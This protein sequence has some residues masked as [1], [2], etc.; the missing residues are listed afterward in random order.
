MTFSNVFPQFLRA[1][2]FALIGELGITHVHSMP[3]KSTLRLEA[4]GAYVSG[5]PVH[6]A[7][8]VQ[9]ATEPD[10]SF[11][12]ATSWGY[13]IRGRF[14]YNNAIGP[15]ALIPSFAW[16]HDVS[17]TTPGPGGNFLDGR[18][19][20]SLGLGTNL[21]NV[22]TADLR[23]TSFFGAGRQNLINDRD[24]VSFTVKLAI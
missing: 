18:K 1:D 23:Y 24:F 19:A 4:P 14:T 21:R 2:Q 7:A 11:P 5:N 16:R 10:S 13:R 6:T 12:D 8:G 20:F 22:W 17:G 15:W 3:S 9:P